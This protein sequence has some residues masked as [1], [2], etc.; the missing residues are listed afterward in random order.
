MET[1]PAISIMPA[2]VRFLRNQ[3]LRGAV[4]DVLILGVRRLAFAQLFSDGFEPLS[5]IHSQHGLL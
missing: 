1:L 2:L 5:I 4:Y 3:P